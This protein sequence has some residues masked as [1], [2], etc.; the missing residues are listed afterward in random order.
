MDKKNKK[1]QGLVE[2]FSWF[3]ILV[4][5]IIFFIL[6]QLPGCSGDTPSQKIEPKHLGEVQ[7]ELFLS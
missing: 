7:D 2:V 5:T 3:L 1:A 4:F 6:F